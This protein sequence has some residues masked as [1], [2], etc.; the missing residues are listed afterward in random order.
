MGGLS[1]NPLKKE[2]LWR[3]IFFHILLNE[4]LKIL[5]CLSH[6]ILVGILSILLLSIK[7]IGGG[8]FFCLTKGKDL[9]YSIFD[10][11]RIKKTYLCYSK[12]F[13]FVSLC[14]LYHLV[15]SKNIRRKNVGS[16]FFG[17]AHGCPY[18]SDITLKHGWMQNCWK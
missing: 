11:F 3:K 8:F 4:V 17:R 12:R 16:S 10:A 6:L 1:T 14:S 9:I 15:F 2:S 18:C 13:L 5:V 7:N